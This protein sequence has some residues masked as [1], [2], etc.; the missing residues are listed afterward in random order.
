MKHDVDIAA[1]DE[2]GLLDAVCDKNG[3]MT[4]YRSIY[5]GTHNFI[6]KFNRQIFNNS[7][8]LSIYQFS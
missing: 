2:K 7:L 6:R 8:F 5:H 4:D 3:A 1:S